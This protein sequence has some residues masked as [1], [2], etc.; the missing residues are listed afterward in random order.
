MAALPAR[1]QEIER[2]YTV[3]E[4]EQMPE[5]NDNFE[6]ING[7][8]IEKPMPGYQHSRIARLLMKAYDAFDPDET[9]GIMLQEAS[10]RLGPKD[11]RTPDVS[12]WKANRRP[13]NGFTGATVPPDLAVEVLSPS[14]L[15]RTARQTKTKG[16]I[17]EFQGVGIALIWSINPENKTVKVYHADPN[18]PVQILDINGELDGEDIIPGFKIKVADLFR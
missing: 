5:F 11:T 3:E 1:P 13:P 10:F 6:L 16:K 15:S 8:L 14:D 17:E 7:R 2:L 9:V 18:K 4:F 12:F